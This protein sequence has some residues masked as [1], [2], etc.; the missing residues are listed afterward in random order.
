MAIV[1]TA[2]DRKARRFFESDRR[3]QFGQP[4]DDWVW[5]GKTACTHTCWQKLIRLWTGRVVSLNA[6]NALAGMPHNAV[7][8]DARGRPI[9][10][11][12]GRRIPRGMRI[13]EAKTLVRKL[14]LPYVLRT[15]VTIAQ[16]RQWAKR[17]PVLYGTRY[18]SMPDKRG[19]VYRGVRAD[20][21]PN[22]FAR[23]NGRTQLTGAENI[24]H[25]VIYV[26]EREVRTS[27]GALARVET[28]RFDPNHGSASR[29]ERP[30]YD[31]ITPGQAA[32]ELADYSATKFAFIP[33]RS[34]P[35]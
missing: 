32:K 2:I 26:C 28:L 18:G 23:V 29:P 24:R 27:T 19:Y 14:G 12:F 13:E 11:R 17:G 20:G 34:L 35:V 22:G 30:A 5:D 3:Q 16:I 1:E 33:T 7:A 25:A 15:N 4:A 21:R 8:T 9:L 6:V 31:V 10:D